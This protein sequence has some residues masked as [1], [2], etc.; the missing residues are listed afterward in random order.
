MQRSW[1]GACLGCS[2]NSEESSVAGVER[3]RCRG[4]E[5]STAGQG[6]GARLCG[7]F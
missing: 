5:T 7:A 2:G 1:V 4:E 6:M 3:A